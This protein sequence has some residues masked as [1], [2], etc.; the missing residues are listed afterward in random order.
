MREDIAGAQGAS[1]RPMWET[2][3]GMVREKAQEFI[4]QIMEEE[5]TE[6]LG[7]EK[8]WTGDLGN[9][10]VQRDGLQ[11]ELRLERNSCPGTRCYRWTKKPDFSPMFAPVWTQSPDFA[12]ATGSVARL[13]TNGSTATRR[14]DP[15][16]SRTGHVGPRLPAS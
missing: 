11:V 5:V 6:L 1:S 10:T 13:A 14:Q 7:R 16:D 15:L 3:E 12:D 2:L 4:Q 8:V 9:R